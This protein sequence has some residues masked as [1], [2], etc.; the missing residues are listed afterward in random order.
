MPERYAML[1]LVDVAWFTTR[2]REDDGGKAPMAMPITVTYPT[3]NF[4]PFGPVKLG[5]P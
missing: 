4:S 2:P 5:K 1:Q 3:E